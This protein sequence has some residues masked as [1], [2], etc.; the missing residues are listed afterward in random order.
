MK[1]IQKMGKIQILYIRLGKSLNSDLKEDFSRL[2]REILQGVFL[3]VL[4]SLK[5]ILFK[6]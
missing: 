6:Q 2:L 4:L 3:F 1:K 5:K